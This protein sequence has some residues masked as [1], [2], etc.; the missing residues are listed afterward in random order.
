MSLVFGQKA[1][2][3]ACSH[4][5][6]APKGTIMSRWG[7]G[8]CFQIGEGINFAPKQSQRGG[9]SETTR[10]GYPLEACVIS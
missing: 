10:V 6:L 8:T 2:L 9:S 1:A 7:G 5:E 3:T 4:V